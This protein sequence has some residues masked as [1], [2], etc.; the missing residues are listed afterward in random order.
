MTMV[1]VFLNTTDVIN[2]MTVEIAVM[3]MDVVSHVHCETEEA[4][5]SYLPT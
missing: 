5:R 2:L 1:N 3:K 4:R